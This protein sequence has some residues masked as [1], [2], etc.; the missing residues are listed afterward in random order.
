[1]IGGWAYNRYA[2]PRTTGDIDFFLSTS[3]EN[4]EKIRKV[5]SLFGFKDALPSKDRSI[6]EKKVIMLGRP[7]HRI[8]LISEIDGITFE[9]AWKNHEKGKLDGLDVKFISKNDLIKN[10]ESTERT[11]DKLDVENLSK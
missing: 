4:E 9:E 10:K 7:P 6:F 8:D 2:E 11:K 3:K 1:M 5:L